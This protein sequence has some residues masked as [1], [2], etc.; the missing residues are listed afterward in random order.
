MG[1]PLG[2]R[3]LEG[4]GEGPLFAIAG[5][6]YPTA[7]EPNYCMATGAAGAVVEISDSSGAVHSL[8]VNTSGNFYYEGAIAYP[9]AAKVL[10]EG[11]ERAMNAVQTSGDCNGCHTQSGSQGA[12]GRILLP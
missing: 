3:R 1:G 8:T 11:R 10:F 5:T 6:V 4:E 2:L 12:P 9:Y 7:H